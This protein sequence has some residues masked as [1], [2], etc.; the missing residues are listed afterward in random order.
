MKLSAIA[1]TRSE[2]AIHIPSSVPS[3]KEMAKPPKMRP[4][5]AKRS[6]SKPPV[7]N[8]VTSAIRIWVGRGK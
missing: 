3:T 1:L 4:N 7:L 6:L 2:V 5:V 8:I